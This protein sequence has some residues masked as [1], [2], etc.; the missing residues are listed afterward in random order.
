MYLANYP[1]QNSPTISTDE[2][3]YDAALRSVTAG[4]ELGSLYKALV[5][6]NID[7][8][9]KRRAGQ[10]ALFLNNRATAIMS[11][12]SY[13]SLGIT[14]AIWMYSGAPCMANPRKPTPQDINQ[15]NAHRAANNKQY[16]ISK[17]MFLDGRWTRP[18]WEEGCRCS[19]RP[20][21]PW[22]SRK[23]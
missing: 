13:A 10:I 16:D 17:G 12:N 14:R 3:I 7:G 2:P 5:K 21:L 8:M 20:I 18:G 22:L 15:D 19:S 9:T 4:R 11:R 1:S 6:V 23:Q